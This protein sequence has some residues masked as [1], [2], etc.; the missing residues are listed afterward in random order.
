MTNTLIVL[1]TLLFIVCSPGII[2]HVKRV[3]FTVV[4]KYALLYFVAYTLIQLAIPYS[5][6]YTNQY[7]CIVVTP[8]GRKRY[9]EI[10]YPYLKQQRHDFYNWN[11]WLNT[12]NEED[13][14]YMRK[15]ERENDWIKCIEADWPIE[16]EFSI[17][18]FFEYTKD[19]N[20]IYIRLD[21]DIAYLTPDFIRTLY[22]ARIANPEPL[23]IYPNIINN[24]VIAHLHYKNKLIDYPSTPGY[25]CMDEVGWKD[26]KFAETLHRAFLE[27]VR[28]NTVNKWKTSF[29]T[30]TPVDFT[31]V[32]IN[33]LAWFGKDMRDVIKTVD[34]EE[35]EFLSRGFPREIN[36]PNLIINYP[37]CAHFAFYTQR[38]HLEEQTDILQQYGALADELDKRIS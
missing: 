9:I 13:I 12:T 23:F 1:Y 21:D 3:N 37:I 31:R 19:P 33:C 25:K 27:S 32:S 5:E 20:T 18:K 30:H 29:T 17:C 22:Q 35:E 38:P 28:T 14:K 11:L 8:A 16:K 6:N 24:A 7:K 10:L 4:I 15:L 34:R 36:R 2:S 26:G